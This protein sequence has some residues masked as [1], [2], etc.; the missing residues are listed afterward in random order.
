MAE[1]PTFCAKSTN[2]PLTDIKVRAL[3][4]K[5]TDFKVADGEGLYLLV[6]TTEAKRWRFAYRFG[7][8]QK[9]L[10]LGVNPRVSLL[11][12][13]R[14]RDAAKRTLAEGNDPSIER[15]VEKQKKSLAAGNTFKV[16]ATEWYDLKKPG[17]A[18]S[19]AVRLKSRLDED[20]LEPLGARL[21]SDIRPL[22]MLDVL[23]AIENRGAVEMAK[24]VK[25]MA[26]GIFCYGMATERCLSDPTASL[27]GILKPPSP[28]KHRKALSASQLPGFMNA[29]SLYDGDEIKKLGLKLV[30]HTLVR[31]AEIRFARWSEFEHFRGREPLWRIP[32][33]RMKM[34]RPHL[35]PLSP[36]ALEMLLT[37]HELTGA[38]EFLLPGPAKTGVISENTLLYAIYRMGYHSRA[39]VHGFRTTASTVL[40]EQQFNR[41]WIEMQLAHFDGSVRGIYNAAE[42]LPGRREMM[43]W[44]SDLV[45]DNLKR[46]RRAA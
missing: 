1:V 41:D 36:Q 4:P 12:A 9:T 42:W 3:R 33:E 22:E 35:V 43:C 14:A 13:R 2:M 27:K 46:R 40:S 34:R 30:I 39:T 10:A 7:G 28:P 19:Y 45:D 21:I 44:W 11:D 25:Q 17:W 24:R 26:S 29:L 38:G 16:V 15:K 6:K 31:T 20:L 18:P 8:K 5:A 37:L 32:A 23:R